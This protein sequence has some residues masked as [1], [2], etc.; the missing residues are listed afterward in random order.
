MTTNIITAFVTAYIATQKP[1]ANGI[2]PTTNHTVAIPRS[3]PLNCKV[4]IDGKWYVGMDRTN[5]KYDG[6][7][8]IFVADKQTALKWGIQKKQITVIIP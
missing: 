5:K 4:E 6:R 2:Y 7:F 3:L 1:C 8:D